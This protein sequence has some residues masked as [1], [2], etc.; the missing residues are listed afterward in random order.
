M[1]SR[2]QRSSGAR[3]RE[4]LAAGRAA[5]AARR[6]VERVCLRLPTPVSVND[7]H[8]PIS[9]G[10]CRSPAYLAWIKEAGWSLNAQRFGRIAGRYTL[11]LGL[12]RECGLDLDNAV[13]ATSDLLQLHGIIRNDRDA[14]HIGL[15]WQDISAETLVIVGPAQDQI[16]MPGIMEAFAP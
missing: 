4:E 1:A 15:W 5:Y 16:A 3:R 7:L 12:P 13:K 14:E 10:I 9:G 6:D 8:A 11:D 2:S